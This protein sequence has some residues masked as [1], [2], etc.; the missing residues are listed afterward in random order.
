MTPSRGPCSRTRCGGEGKEA[1][2]CRT[3][4]LERRSEGAGPLPPPCHHPPPSRCCCLQAEEEGIA[5]IENIAGA[6]GH[7]NYDAIPGV[8]Y[9]YP[10]VASV[11]K[12]EEELKAAG[13]A[14]KK[15]TFP[16]MANSRARAMQARDEGASMGWEAGAASSPPCREEGGGRARLTHPSPKP[17]LAA[18]RACAC[19]TRRAS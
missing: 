16:F 13:V 12:T 3:G 10:E 11:G 6:H 14:Y 9:T 17:P 5:A 1:G 18:M 19:R 2:Y 7:V 4:R 15:G 8:V